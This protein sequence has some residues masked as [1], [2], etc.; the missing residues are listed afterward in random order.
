LR[1]ASA[2]SP[3]RPR[4]GRRADVGELD[5]ERQAICLLAW[6]VSDETAHLLHTIVCDFQMIPWKTR[7][8]NGHDLFHAAR[9]LWG[10][11]GRPS[12][13]RPAS[14]PRG[15]TVA[16]ELDRRLAEPS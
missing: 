11:A 16:A 5:E 13:L 3:R 7:V 8:G 14:D 9:S 15:E 12:G 6:L 4:A 10:S 1:T 2:G